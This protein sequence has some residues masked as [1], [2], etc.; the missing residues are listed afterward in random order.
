MRGALRII[1][2]THNHLALGDSREATENAYQSGLRP[3]LSTLY[4]FPEIPAALHY[5]GLL[6]EWVET[7]HPEFLM[8]LTEMV[9]RRQVEVLG[10]AYYDPFLPMI[11]AN[12]R[13]G[14]IEKMTTQLRVR[15]ETRPRGCWLAEQVWEPSLASVLR[16][17]G[18]DYTVLA[19]TQ[20]RLAG[21]SGHALLDA[22]V[23]E[24]QGKQIA[25]VPL[26]TEFLVQSERLSPEEFLEAIRARAASSP[27]ARDGIVCLI[28]DGTR[29]GAPFARNGWLERFLALVRENRSWLEPVGPGAYLRE[30]PPNRRIYLPCCSSDRVAAWSL[31]PS[32]RRAWQE[33]R[34]RAANDP[35]LA[36]VL[37]GGTFRQFFVR[38]PEAGMLYAKMLHTHLVVNQLRGDRYR[39]RAAQNELWKGQC[40]HAYWFSGTDGLYSNAWRKATYRSLI[41]AEK[42][43]RATE[44]F[45]PSINEVD[46]DLDNRSEYLYQGSE[47]NAYLHARGGALFELD[48]LPAS[49]N[50]LDTLARR[51][52][53]R[54]GRDRYPRQAFLDH[55]LP[56]SCTLGEFAA[57]GCAEA[58]SFIEE[59]YET[60]ELNR[61]LPE[62]LL[63]VRG[64][65]RTSTREVETQIEKRYVFR[66]R[67]IDV[68]YR[69]G[70]EGDGLL[71]TR[72]GVEINVSL[73]QR[74]RDSGRLFLV[75]EGG[76]TEIGHDPKEIASATGL[77]VRDVRNEVSIVLSSARP[78][79][80]WSMPV[81]TELPAEEGTRRIFQGHCVVPLWQLALGPGQVWEN[82]LSIGFEKAAESLP[83]EP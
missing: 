17:G 24:D 16:T 59:T 15:F 32:R 3:F 29:A 19:D 28:A 51:D 23:V 80:C 31:S 53:G 38:Y 54:G 50:Y 81:E 83:R 63:R 70:V 26:A 62:V 25:V 66:P 9:A 22:Y 49:W 34:E 69:I 37:A 5:S 74:S 7:E 39:K 2:G 11:P 68:Y 61:T 73:A 27:E 40:H 58:A 21:L 43:I 67:S 20:L 8:L 72:L 42:I 12:D 14:Q 6:L 36:S 56:E 30:R 77:L 45:A 71:E 4:A 44:I 18:V 41:E 10:G 60:V 55:F 65:V 1:I 79:G 33:A 13:L 46:F 78:F 35:E 48:F 47:L 82:H 75:D 76:A 64:P 57:G 52:E